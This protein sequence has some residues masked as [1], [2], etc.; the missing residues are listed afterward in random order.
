MDRTLR[1]GVGPVQHEHHSDLR[2][3]LERLGYND[4]NHVFLQVFDVGDAQIYQVAGPMSSIKASP[5]R[6]TIHD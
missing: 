2:F 6:S 4:R 1:V 5:Q 3:S